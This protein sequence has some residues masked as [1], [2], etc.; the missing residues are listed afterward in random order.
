MLPLFSYFPNIYLPPL[1]CIYADRYLVSTRTLLVSVGTKEHVTLRMYSFSILPDG[2]TPSLKTF[3]TVFTLLPG[4]QIATANIFWAWLHLLHSVQSSE[5]VLTFS[6]QQLVWITY[7]Y[8]PHLTNEESE[9]REVTD[10]AT[11]SQN[12]DLNLNN[13]DHSPCFNY[14]P[15]KCISALLF[16]RMMK[17]ILRLSFIF[18]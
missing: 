6:S 15:S 2:L 8:D 16:R 13:Q 18:F 3:P 4:L 14:M 1:L 9:H 11:E 12:E 10:P 17:V 5:N 7:C